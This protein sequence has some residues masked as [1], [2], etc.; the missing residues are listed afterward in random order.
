M[1]L[2]SDDQTDEDLRQRLDSPILAIN[3]LVASTRSGRSSEPI[4][5]LE[6]LNVD[7]FGANIRW[8]IDIAHL[9]P[10]WNISCIQYLSCSIENEQLLL[11][12]RAAFPFQYCSWHWPKTTDKYLHFVFHDYLFLQSHCHDYWKLS[13][14]C[15]SAFSND[16]CYAKW[17]F[18]GCE[19]RYST[20]HIVSSDASANT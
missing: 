1:R 4:I 3:F 8:V 5:F 11:A 6:F 18:L 10:L 9:F 19:R 20:A 17:V 16:K 15:H 7:C 12:M 13:Q 14:L 2:S